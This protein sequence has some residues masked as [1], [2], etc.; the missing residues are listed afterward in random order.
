MQALAIRL[1]STSRVP[2]KALKKT[3]KKTRTMTS[4]TLEVRPRP[5]ATMKSDPSTIRG[6]EF[7]ILM[8]GPKTSARNWIR[9]SAIP[10]TTPATT[11]MTKPSAASSRVTWICANKD[12]W[13]VP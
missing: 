3:P 13:D 2:W 1:R 4:S 7:M 5:K 12:P 6:M 11:P 9:P 10:A 8:N